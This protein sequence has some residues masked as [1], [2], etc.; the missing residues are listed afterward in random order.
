MLVDAILD[1]LEQ[2]A[3]KVYRAAMGQVAAFGQA[4]SQDGIA[5]CSNAR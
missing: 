1:R 2:A 3:G 5:G 4:H